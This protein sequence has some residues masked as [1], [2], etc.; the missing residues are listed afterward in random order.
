MDLY[1]V[2]RTTAA[3]RRFT[4]EP[5]P[6]DVVYRILDNAR[7]APSG[8]NRQ[9]WRVVLIKDRTSRLEIR[10]CYQLG[11][12]DYQA[13]V[14]RGLVPFAPVDN[15][16]WNSPAVDLDEAR[17]TPRPN[18]F[19]DMLEDVPVM[20]AV[21]VELGVLAVLDNGLGRQS[22][23]GGASVYA[24]A[25]NVLLAARNE[26]LG[27]VMTTMLCRE[28]PRVLRLLGAREGC[29]LATLIVLGHPMRIV[30]KLTRR[31][32]EEFASI[33]HLGGLA[34]SSHRERPGE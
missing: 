24:F 2:M 29:A 12:R 28:E 33:D 17:A 15:G 10:E 11:W 34:L 18:D 25:Q 22:I 30:T 27:G 16:C 19:V 14:E 8:G 7:F 6:D 23:V 26:G 9:G 5:V 21:V 13:H 4:D 31:S 3:T 20:L 1:E 32:V